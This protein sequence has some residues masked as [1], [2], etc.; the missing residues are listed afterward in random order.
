MGELWCSYTLRILF[1]ALIGWTTSSNSPNEDHRPQN[2]LP[3]G[4][5]GFCSS[6]DAPAHILVFTTLLSAGAG[7]KSF[8]DYAAN[9][10]GFAEGSRSR[11]T[12]AAPSQHVIMA[13]PI[14]RWLWSRVSALVS[15]VSFV[16]PFIDQPR[17][18]RRMDMDPSRSPVL[19]ARSLSISSTEP[20]TSSHRRSGSRT[21]Y[22]ALSSHG[23][24]KE[25]S[26]LSPDS[27]VTQPH[28]FSGL[29]PSPRPGSHRFSGL[30]SSPRPSEPRS[31][32]PPV[33]PMP[34]LSPALSGPMS[35]PMSGKSFGTFID[36]EPSTPAYSPRMGSNWEG[37]TLVLLPPVKSDDSTPREPRWDMLVPLQKPPKKRF[38]R[39][40]LKPSISKDTSVG[41]PRFSHPVRPIQ[42]EPQKENHPPLVEEEE[43][44]KE[45]GEGPV[46]SDPLG[47][48]ATRMKSLLK[49][50]G[51]SEKKGRRERFEVER[52]ETVH[53]TEL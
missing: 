22:S 11:R 15:G 2:R 48:L 52:V 21:E 41:A 40:K 53:W 47:K 7:A 19:S 14:L 10:S 13:P 50:R 30:P 16:Y 26:L 43:E 35:P 12:G 37:S 27:L 5:V 42:E 23:L 4:P 39:H 36:S 38:S 45:G 51:N 34:A 8:V 44:K 31:P 18:V 49:R 17:V 3:R 29:P 6:W 20:K 28:R 25:P 33:S 24:P 32:L 9:T 46:Q 1:C